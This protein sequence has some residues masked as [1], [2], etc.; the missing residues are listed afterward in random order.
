MS[1]PYEILGVAPTA[2]LDEIKS[3]YRRLARKLH[4][5]LNPGDKSGEERFKDVGN[6][7]RLLSDPDKRARFD[8][9]QIDADGAERPQPRYYRD[10][11]DA[12]PSGHYA[13]DSGFAD[14]ADGDDPFAELLRRQAHA[15][16]NRRGQ[17]L[18]YRLP[19]AFAESIE[20]GTKRLTMPD[21]ST[22]DVT[23]PAGVVD[24]QILRLK[25]KGA[26]GAGQGGPGDALVEIEV[27]ADPRFS[28]DGDD[29]TLELPVSL[30]EA[31]LGDRIRV[32]TPT[33]EATMT[34]PPGSN[35]GTV[36]RLKGM[37]APRR[38]GGRGDQYVRLTI[39]L[40][41][42]GDPE[43]TKFVSDW[44][45]GKAFNPRGEAKA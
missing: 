40:P 29:L 45:A 8:A 13:N 27:V 7:Y 12:E 4:P 41:K 9:G 20:A 26:P 10:Y 14:F 19:I 22:I 43:L 31:V 17:D 11:A 23:I 44:S 15:R 35:S 37:G 38:G 16:A 6:A 18:H 36:L 33:G 34:I 1:S 2:S 28:R 25:G 39:V 3:A 24:G 21:G 5:D 30:T 32:A 42:G